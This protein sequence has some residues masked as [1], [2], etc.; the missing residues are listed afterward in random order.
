MYAMDSNSYMSNDEKTR[1]DSLDAFMMATVA[2]LREDKGQKLQTR[3]EDLA[4]QHGTIG[5]GA[6]EEKNNMLL[7]NAWNLLRNEISINIL[8]F[9][10]CP[11]FS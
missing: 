4:S 2:E 1:Q 7:L 3:L 9:S 6:L 8:K 5:Q 10:S 11:L